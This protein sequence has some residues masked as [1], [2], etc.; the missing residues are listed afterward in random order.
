MIIWGLNC[1]HFSVR[2]PVPGLLDKKGENPIFYLI[3]DEILL[4]LF[5]LDEI[6]L[7]KNPE[8]K[9]LLTLINKTF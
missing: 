2:L 9:N 1:G 4:P 7:M 8:V 3:K 5:C 6:V